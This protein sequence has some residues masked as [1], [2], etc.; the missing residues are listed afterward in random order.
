M[1]G[2]EYRLCACLASPDI[3][4]LEL[5]PGCWIMSMKSSEKQR[6]GTEVILQAYRWLYL[7]YGTT[8][9]GFFRASVIAWLKCQAVIF[10]SRLQ[11]QITRALIITISPESKNYNP[12]AIACGP[13]P[14]LLI[15]MTC[16]RNCLKA[17]KKVTRRHR[18]TRW[19]GPGGCSSHSS[20]SSSN[21]TISS[22]KM[23]IRDLV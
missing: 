12:N 16:E 10:A 21:A 19:K 14:S 20:S 6:H 22:K 11:K 7:F 13:G 9:S 2:W 1:W 23:Q 3:D 5:L 4:W 17:P 15:S 18:S 8:A